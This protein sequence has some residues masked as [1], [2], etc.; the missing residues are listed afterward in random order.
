MICLLIQRIGGVFLVHGLCGY[1]VRKQSRSIYTSCVA[2]VW[3]N[4]DLHVS[5]K[6]KKKLYTD[7]DGVKN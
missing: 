2:P 7:K 1:N 3:I 5:I 4:S 6:P